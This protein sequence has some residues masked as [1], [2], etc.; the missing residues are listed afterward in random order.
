MEDLD[1]SWVR[2]FD[3]RRCNQGWMDMNG[4]WEKKKRLISLFKEALIGWRI[5][6][7]FAKPGSSHRFCDFG[8]AI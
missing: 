2:G 6:D 7:V 4:R 3:I 1:L 5:F 8:S